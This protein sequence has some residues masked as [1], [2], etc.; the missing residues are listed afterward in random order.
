MIVRRHHRRDG[1]WTL[2]VS[3]EEFHD[4]HHALRMLEK[5]WLPPKGEEADRV[6][7]AAATLW[8]AH[9]ER[10]AQTTGKERDK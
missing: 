5:S 9:C 7:R 6:T 10:V 4:I 2:D 8:N 3:G 1:Y